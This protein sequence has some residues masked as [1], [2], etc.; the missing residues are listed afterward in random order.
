VDT[1][2]FNDKFRFDA[3]GHPHTEKLH[4]VERSTRTDW[5]NMRMEVMIEDPGAYEKP[6]NTT[7]RA[8]LM[9]GDELLEYICQENDQDAGN[10]VG[11]A[12]LPTEGI[13]E[14]LRKPD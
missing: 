3:L 9:P 5:G 6:F 7:G 13:T 10:Y 12:R 14:P 1:I 8:R 11:P 2:G 4:T